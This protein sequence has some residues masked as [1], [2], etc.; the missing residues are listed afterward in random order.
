MKFLSVSAFFFAMIISLASCGMTDKDY[1]KESKIESDMPQCSN[2]NYLVQSVSASKKPAVIGWYCGD[3]IYE[4]TISGIIVKQ[5]KNDK[6][7]TTFS[8]DKY[9]LNAEFIQ[10]IDKIENRFL[11]FGVKNSYYTDDTSA[12]VLL[13]H[14]P[15]RI[16]TIIPEIKAA[17]ISLAGNNIIFENETQKEIYKYDNGIFVKTN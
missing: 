16:V 13:N 8:I 12:R 4:Q 3:D 6:W 9:G 5:Y 15:F 11:V 2:L 10:L 14:D 7:E 1:I 17:K